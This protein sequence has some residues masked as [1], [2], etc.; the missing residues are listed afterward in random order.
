MTRT[1]TG[2]FAKS[3]ASIE[4]EIAAQRMRAAL[5][6]EVPASEHARGVVFQKACFRSLPNSDRMGVVETARILPLF[7]RAA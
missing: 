7:E 2:R 5:E 4:A 1:P 3:P 6:V